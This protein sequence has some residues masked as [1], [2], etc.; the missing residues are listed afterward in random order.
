MKKSV[1]RAYARLIA[2]SGVN[3]QK[4][5]EV[6]ITAGLDQPEFVAM[7]VEEC[8]RRK[9]KKVVVDWNYQPLTRLHVRHQSL[10]TMS[11][12]DNYE[13]ARWQHYVDTIPC[14]IYLESDDPDG[15]RGVNQEK[16]AKAQQKKYPIIKGYRDQIEN[17]YQWCIAAVP[18]VKWAKKLFPELRA[19][20]AVEKLWEAI[21][22]TSRVDDDPVAAWDAHNKDLKSRCD[23]LNGLGIRELQYRASNGT[24][25]RVGMIP[26]A[27]FCGGG[28]TSLQGIFFNPNIPTEECFIS[29]KRGVAEGIV[30]SSKPLSYQGQLIDR[31]WIRFREGKAAEWGAEENEALLTKLI[32]MDEGSAYLGECALVPFNSPINETGILFYNTLFDENACCHLALGM[33]F[34]DTIRD[35]EH[36]TLDECRALGVNDSMIHEDFMIG[37]ADLSIDALCEDGRTVPLF[38]NGTWAF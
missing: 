35:F 25:L 29:P 22:H 33:G 9:A 3:V 21:L 18:G 14:R 11:T 34:A 28:E 12:L 36:K 26:E 37:T 1:L 16:M 10:T 24:D 23:Y 17:K 8:Y 27:Q 20:Q 7:V 31:F 6:F 13:E 5:Q 4:G 2:E 30:Y 19:S 32:T 38:R 15:L